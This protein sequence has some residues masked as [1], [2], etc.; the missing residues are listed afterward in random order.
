MGRKLWKII[1]PLSLNLEASLT[2]DFL[3]YPFIHRYYLLLGK[4][5]TEDVRCNRNTV[6]ND[7]FYSNRT[8]SE[9]I[10]MNQRGSER[11]R[12]ILCSFN[13]EHEF[14]YINSQYSTR[15]CIGECL[16]NNEATVIISIE[17]KGS[18][19]SMHTF[20]WFQLREVKFNNWVSLFSLNFCTRSKTIFHF[21]IRERNIR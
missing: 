3:I 12:R 18:F 21:H 10:L 16:K 7:R 8:E 14:C 15:E 13:S 1:S 4:Q 5:I 17:G 20:S 11:G 6:C 9:L 2:K 19:S